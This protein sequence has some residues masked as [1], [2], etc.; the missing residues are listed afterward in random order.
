MTVLDFGHFYVYEDP[1]RRIELH[2]GR[3]GRCGPTKFDLGGREEEAPVQMNTVI[4]PTER[5]F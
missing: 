1:C 3:H 5:R 4:I 2:R